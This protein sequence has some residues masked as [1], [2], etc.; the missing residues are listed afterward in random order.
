M[1][2]LSILGSKTLAMGVA[3]GIIDQD[4]VDIAGW[5]YGGYLSYL[6]VT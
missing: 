5:S 4:S 2:I 3:N 6:A 1:G